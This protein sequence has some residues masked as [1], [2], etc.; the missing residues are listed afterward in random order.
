MEE[1]CCTLLFLIVSIQAPLAESQFTEDT[2]LHISYQNHMCAL[3]S[4]SEMEPRWQ[5][6]AKSLRNYFGKVTKSF[7]FANSSLPT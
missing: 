2:P 3:H 5:Q 4:L 1:Q 7:G 6:S